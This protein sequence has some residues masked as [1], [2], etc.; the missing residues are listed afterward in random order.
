MNQEGNE[1]P[2]Q[3]KNFYP[4]FSEV[5]VEIFVSSRTS[6]RKKNLLKSECCTDE[7]PGGFKARATVHKRYK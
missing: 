4:G 2:K 1:R 7:L 5:N 6:Y 3:T